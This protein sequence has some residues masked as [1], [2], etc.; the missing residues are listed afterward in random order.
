[1]TIQITLIH[2]LTPLHAGTGQAVGA[3]DLPIA[4]ERPTGIP[5]L[6]GSSL[7]GAC[8]RAPAIRGRLR[9]WVRTPP[10]P[11]TARAPSQFSD[12]HLLLLPVRSL[13]AP[14]AWVTSPYLLQ[15]F[16][17]DVLEAGIRLQPPKPQTPSSIA[18]SRQALPYGALPPGR[19]V[20]EDLDFIPDEPAELTT[21]AKRLD[22]WLHAGEAPHACQHLCVV[23]DNVMST[24]METATEVN[25]R[26]A[27][28]DE[29]KT[30]KRSISRTRS[31]CRPSRCSSASPPRPAPRSGTTSPALAASCSNT[32]TASSAER[33][34]S[35][36]ARPLSAAACVA[37]AS[38]EVASE[39]QSGPCSPRIHT[40]GASPSTNRS[41]RNTASWR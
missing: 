12:A 10:M 38:S 15:R 6:P 14:C 23:H 21:L 26:I 18:S 11:A 9:S 31:P 19:V 30:V 36:A 27:L 28:N 1:M 16:A 17:R 41:G 4:R 24:L 20:L 40:S 33:P 7:K 22:E 2:A 37:C 34:S 29:T 35:S 25:A 3:I 13:W 39:P 32:S 8:A 5:L